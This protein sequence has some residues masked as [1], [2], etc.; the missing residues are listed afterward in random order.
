MP[1]KTMALLVGSTLAV[2]AVALNQALQVDKGPAA[3][4]TAQSAA[5]PDPDQTVR[6]LRWGPMSVG[7]GGFVTGL[8][9]AKDGTTVV[10]T[11][12]YGGY[13]WDAKAQRWQQLVRAS[14]MP[15]PYAAVD[16]G[17]GAYE[18]V[19]AQSRPNIFYLAYLDTVFRSDDRG[20]TWRK[21]SFGPIK[22]NANENQGHGSKMAVDPRNPDHLLVGTQTDGMWRSSDGGRSFTKTSLPNGTAHPNGTRP[23]ILGI[24]FNP[25]SG[26][27]DGRTAEVIASSFGHGAYR[28]GDGGLTWTRTPGGPNNAIRH[29]CAA[30]DGSIYAT[31]WSGPNPTKYGENRLWRWKAG[32]TDLGDPSNKQVNH[33]VACDPFDPARIV[34]GTEGGHLNQSLDRGATWTGLMWEVTRKATDIPWLAWTEEGY[35]TNGEQRFHPTIRNRIMFAQ[36]I[37]VWFTDLAPNAKS[38]EWTSQSRGIEQLVANQ[39]LAPPGGKPV[40]ASWDRPLFYMG[41]PT[42]PDRYPG[43]HGPDRVDSIQMGWAVDYSLSKPSHLVALVN[44]GKEKSGYSTDG[45]KSWRVFPSQP[46][47]G[48]TGKLGGGIAVSTPAYY[49]N[50]HIIASDKAV[51]GTFYAYNYLRGLYR[52]QNGGDSWTLVKSGELT[53]WSGFN[54]ELKTV[55]GKAGHLFFTAGHQSGPSNPG[56]VPLVRSVDGGVSWQPVPNV[57]EVYS[58]GFGKSRDPG[59]YPTIFIAGW[60]NNVY[61]VWMSDDNAQSWRKMASF[62]NDSLDMIKTLDGDK[63]VY[64]RVYVGFGGSSYAWGQLPRG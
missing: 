3:V 50:R 48:A 26:V 17:A 13:L 25:A 57:K 47:F 55:P 37:G 19:I 4:V 43:S 35:M 7:A 39:V 53:S 31:D 16:N 28:S 36:G 14:S 34:V 49:L 52:S 38:V 60:V 42:S 44:W 45:G 58:F 1:W 51:P 63:T 18:L 21:T 22:F 15:A 5:A 61:G 8:D 23:G 33:S 29:A 64:G 6:E 20:R 40:L 46:N 27:R 54:A 9:I 56:D 59:G 62:P 41:A 10:R 2:A 12:T 30:T 11:D 24:T 32:W